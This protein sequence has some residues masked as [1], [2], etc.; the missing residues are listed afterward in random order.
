MFTV[1]SWF[2][3]LTMSGLPDLRPI[4]ERP[5]ERA[6]T[7]Q[8]CGGLRAIQPFTEGQPS[9]EFAL[10]ADSVP[11]NVNS[12]SGYRGLTLRSARATL[13]AR[14]LA[15][16]PASA[17]VFLY[18]LPE[19]GKTAP[20]ISGGCPEEEETSPRTASMPRKSGGFM[21][22]RRRRV[23]PYFLLAPSL[24]SRLKVGASRIMRGTR[25]RIA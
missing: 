13:V 8:T 5:C 10:Q 11:S 22:G 7:V 9:T 20:R 2:D 21:K 16:H 23:G 12:Y 4:I 24:V 14:G 6:V 19:S 15:L 17:G 25:L 1:R 3:R 18:T